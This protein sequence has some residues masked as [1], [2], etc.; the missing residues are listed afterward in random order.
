MSNFIS[1]LLKPH[2]LIRVFISEFLVA[3]LMTFDCVSWDLLR[4]YHINPCAFK[5]NIMF[6]NKLS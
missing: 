2:D 6:K 1:G 3:F 4:N 5:C